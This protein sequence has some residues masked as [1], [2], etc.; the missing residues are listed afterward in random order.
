M[1]VIKVTSQLKSAKAANKLFYIHIYSY[2]ENYSMYKLNSS[3]SV[4]WC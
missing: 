2:L 3:Y 1:N 4:E